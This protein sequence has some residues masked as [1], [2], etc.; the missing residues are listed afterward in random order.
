MLKSAWYATTSL[1]SACQHYPEIAQSYTLAALIRL[2]TTTHNLFMFNRS[3]ISSNTSEKLSLLAD[4]T[5]THL[6]Y[7]RL[8]QGPRYTVTR[9]TVACEQ[10]LPRSLVCRPAWTRFSRQKKTWFGSKLVTSI[11]ALVQESWAL[12]PC[13]RGQKLRKANNIFFCS[14]NLHCC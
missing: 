10:A 2:S 13:F 14:I 4:N 7:T 3:E 5:S 9:S 6:S 12:D 8:I 1:N 11:F